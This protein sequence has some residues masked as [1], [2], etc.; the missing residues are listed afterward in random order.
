MMFTAVMHPEEGPSLE[1]LCTIKV[2]KTPI[3]SLGTGQPAVPITE[4]Q[5]I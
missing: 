2:E 3:C 5:P 1:T 4:E